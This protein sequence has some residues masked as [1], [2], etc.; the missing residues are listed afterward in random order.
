M[1]KARLVHLPESPQRHSH[2]HHQLVIGLTG[3]SNLAVNGREARLESGAA[4]VVPT[5]AVHDFH[6]DP[7]NIVWVIDLDR[8]SPEFTQPD[9]PGRH[10]FTHLFE[11]PRLI[12]LSKPVRDLL[13]HYREQM[14][15]A[16]EADG[17][18]YH[19]GAAITQLTV[20]CLN[21]ESEAAPSRMDRVQR[22]IDMNL[23]QPLRVADMVDLMCMSVSH[24]QRRFRSE[25][26]CSPRRFLIERRL[27]RAEILLREQDLSIEE[28]SQRVGFCGQSAL[29]N[30]FN[31][32]RD[33]TPGQWRKRVIGTGQGVNQ[34]DNDFESDAFFQKY[35]AFLQDA[36]EA[37]H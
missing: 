16:D 21:L 33:C 13:W 1:L 27:E 2:A 11:R 31:K 19:L 36:E 6:G 30:A 23:D 24:F 12:R 9:H 22:F 14:R 15:H 18:G 34:G 28:V 3:E 32:Y 4:A 5:Y 7:A 35:D 17:L 29:T 10:A 8:D 25:A 20:A 37:D 26:G